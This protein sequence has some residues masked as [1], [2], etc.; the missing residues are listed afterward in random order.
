MKLSIVDQH[1]NRQVVEV[2]D[3][4]IQGRYLILFREDTHDDS[5]VARVDEKKPFAG[6]YGAD[7]EL[8]DE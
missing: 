6:L 5:V 1:G 2:D 8:L 3:F 7:W 4:T